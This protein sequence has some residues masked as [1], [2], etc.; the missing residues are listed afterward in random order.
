MFNN[1]Y[2]T[3]LS[4]YHLY[5]EHP[6]TFC[7]LSNQRREKIE[8]MFKALTSNSF[9]VLWKAALVRAPRLVPTAALRYTDPGGPYPIIVNLSSRG[10][11]KISCYIFIKH[12][13]THEEA[14]ALPVII[15]FHGGGFFLGS[16]LEQAPF[17]S[18]MARELAAVV[19][20][21]DYRMGPIHKFPAAIEDAED[22]LKAVLEPTSTAGVELR[23]AVQQKILE[24]FATTRRELSEK[25]QRSREA[26]SKYSKPLIPPVVT[27]P[28]D[29]PTIA[30][31]PTRISISGF[32]SGGN[33]ALNLAISLDEP[34]WPSVIDQKY[35]H[36]IPLLLYYPSL[37]ARQLPSER[38]RPEH[39]PVSSSFWSGVSDVLAPTYLPREEA[40]HLRASPGLAD[41][42]TIHKSARI[43]LVLPGVDS[44]AEQSETWVKK[45][46]DDGS[47]VDYLRVERYPTMKHGWTQFPDQM[48][49]GDEKKTKID[50]FNK[51]V[52][53]VRR[54]WAGDDGV[55]KV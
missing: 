13:L 32:S 55:M 4:P 31:D 54:V 49:G 20:T 15:D 44:L 39:L 11:Y 17:C 5:Y 27:S 35:M 50:I 18:K 37:D 43:L 22:V 7:H 24:N 23:A 21:V 51:T 38:S 26:E 28:A 41:I 9:E 33:L 52:E 53:L 3:K 25:E 48:I 30:L 36:P 14:A 19:I 47:R 40:G 46:Q 45:I 34:S 29:P 2:T 10:S 1:V 16:C 12:D 42:S 6:H 8:K